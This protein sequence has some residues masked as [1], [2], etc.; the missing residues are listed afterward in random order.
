MLLLTSLAQIFLWMA[1]T[2][3]NEGHEKSHEIMNGQ[4]ITNVRIVFPA[5]RITAGSLL[6]RDGRIAALN[7]ANVPPGAMTIDGCGGLLTPGL[8]DVHTHGIQKFRYHYDTPPEHF[9]AAARVLGQYGATCVFPTVVPADEPNLVANLSRLPAALPKGT[10]SCMPGIHLEGPFVALSGAGCA[11]FPGDLK[12]LD[13]SE[14]RRV[15]KE[16]RTRL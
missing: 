5:E 11:P 4:F 3:R 6:L 9:E 8:I 2:R 10:G 16:C 15:G 13:R 12:L 1:G 7:P 14:E